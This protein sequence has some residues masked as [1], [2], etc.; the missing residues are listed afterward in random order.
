MNEAQDDHFGLLKDI[1]IVIHA[2]IYAVFNHGG[3]YDTIP[4][5]DNLR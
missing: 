2:V 3:K 1:D 4:G 5:F